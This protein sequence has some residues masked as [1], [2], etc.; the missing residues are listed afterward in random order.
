MGDEYVV[1]R[2]ENG[3]TKEDGKWFP[4]LSPRM[5]VEKWASWY[6]AWGADYMIVGGSDATVMVADKTGREFSYIV[7]GESVPS[8]RAQLVVSNA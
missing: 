8:Y 7:S 1:W 5:A 3:Q 2:P 4:A 6:D